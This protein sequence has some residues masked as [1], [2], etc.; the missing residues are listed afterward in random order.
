VVSFTSIVNLP[1][2]IHSRSYYP[3]VSGVLIEACVF[4][5]ATLVRMLVS[6]LNPPARWL[7]ALI[8]HSYAI[9]FV[10]HMA[11]VFASACMVAAWFLAG[12]CLN[13]NV[14]LP[15][16]VAFLVV[17]IACRTVGTSMALTARKLADA[18]TVAVKKQLRMKLE[19]AK[20]QMDLMAQARLAKENAQW[21][22]SF[23]SPLGPVLEE[24]VNPSGASES[25]REV[26]AADIFALLKETRDAEREDAGEGA[27]HEEEIEKLDFRRLFAALD[28]DLSDGQLDRL[29]AMVDLSGSDTISLKEFESA[30]DL[31]QEEILEGY[32]AEMGLS[33]G[34]IVMAIVYVF[35]MIVLL[36]TFLLL[37]LSSWV[38]EDSFAAVIKSGL[39]AVVGQNIT[40]AR[41]K[42]KAELG[43]GELDDVVAAVVGE[44]M[45]V[46]SDD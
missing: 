20:R 44:Q 45:A 17:V 18:I 14:Y 3:A 9:I 37:V 41:T 2:L 36:L 23:E 1:D 12:A 5:L 33:T 29:F 7:Q 26:T 6:Y 4:F 42:A 19:R 27:T 35:V 31:L 38:G 46:A 28:L 40:N 10:I 25:D 43:D 22:D 30:W 8:V 34:Q 15:Y 13:P 39:I 21:D 32:M 11:L 16:A 24:H